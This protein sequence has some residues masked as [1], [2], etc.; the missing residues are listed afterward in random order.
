MSPLI[1]Q[2]QVIIPD[3]M[4]IQAA[5]DKLDGLYLCSYSQIYIIIIEKEA[6]GMRRICGRHGL[7]GQGGHGM[8]WIKGREGRN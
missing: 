1:I 5:L 4:Y 8:D 3:I 6:M 7:T 2:Y